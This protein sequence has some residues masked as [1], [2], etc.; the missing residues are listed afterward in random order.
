[1]ERPRWPKM[2]PREPPIAQDYFQNCSRWPNMHQDCSQDAPRGPKTS[3]RRLQVATEPPTEAPQE[4]KVFQN[5]KKNNELCILAFL[6]S[7]AF[8]GLKTAPR[9]QKTAPRELQVGPKSSRAIQ[10]RSKRGPRGD[11]WGPRGA[12]LIEAPLF[13]IDPLQDG[14]KSAPEKAGGSPSNGP[15]DELTRVVERQ[16]HGL[17]RTK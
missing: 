1:M 8:R 10:E 17:Q 5:L 3:P 9:G 12:S 14:P 15:K 2:A 11:F 4:A 6:F 7:L 13:L 16:M